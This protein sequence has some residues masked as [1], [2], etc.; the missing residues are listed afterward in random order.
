MKTDVLTLAVSLAVIPQP[1][2]LTRFYDDVTWRRTADD[3]AMADVVL[4]EHLADVS[5]F[6]LPVDVAGLLAVAYDDRLLSEET[7]LTLQT[8]G[9]WRERHGTPVAYVL[10]TTQAQTYRLF[11]RPDV[12][13]QPLT[14]ATGQP[15]GVDL[16]PDVAILFGQSNP[17]DWP[18]IFDLE[19][20]CRTLADALR[21]DTPW[22]D[23]A[24]AQWADAMVRAAGACVD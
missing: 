11:P 12:P 8:V 15:Y 18:D 7:E 13:S 19:L 24:F 20:A 22:R 1:N 5:T 4:V 16:P 17:Q 14:F 2:D 6:T 21:A 23:A 3:D 9:N 10:D